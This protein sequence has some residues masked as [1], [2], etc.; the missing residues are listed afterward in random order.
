MSGNTLVSIKDVCEMTTLSRSAINQA[1]AA[2]NFPAA[3]SL[4]EKRIAFVHSEVQGWIDQRV[5]ARELA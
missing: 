2:G 3:V 4:G 5:S 1:R